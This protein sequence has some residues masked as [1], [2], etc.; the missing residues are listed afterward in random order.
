MFEL[1]HEYASTGMAAYAKLQEREFLL[2]EEAGYSA[3]RHQRFVG[4][5]YFDEVA[6]TIAGGLAS[7]AA[8]TGSTEEEQFAAA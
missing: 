3:V 7:T 1:A 5:G 8:L 6:N 4:T 2:S